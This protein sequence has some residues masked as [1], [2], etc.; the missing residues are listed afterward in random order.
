MRS[1]GRNTDGVQA[2]F[3]P[4]IIE[5]NGKKV[6]T[7][8]GPTALP[9]Y[10]DM[11]TLEAQK[12]FSPTMEF[13]SPINIQNGKVTP[14]PMYGG[15]PQ[16]PELALRGLDERLGDVTGGGVPDS[17]EGFM[18]ANFMQ[19]QLRRDDIFN[20]KQ[21]LDLYKTQMT[22]LP[23]LM[24]EERM[25]QR[26]PSDINYQDSQAMYQRGLTE[27]LPATNQLREAQAALALQQAQGV[28]SVKEQREANLDTQLY[29]DATALAKDA[30]KQSYGSE[31][32]I[33]PD[34]LGQY[35]ASIYSGM[36]KGHKNAQAGKTPIFNKGQ[37][38]EKSWYGGVKQPALDPS[39]LWQ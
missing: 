29:K 9:N 8:L 31:S 23:Q 19:N 34:V 30:L 11:K 28:M 39:I 37:A 35:I 25:R 33:P 22:A 38:E 13:T 1:F 27:S 21:A 3:G 15:V 5:R 26:L 14:N 17:M 7:N 10:I 32:D 12:G 36:I 24:Q 2:P 6:L 4:R 16:A 18:V 20:N